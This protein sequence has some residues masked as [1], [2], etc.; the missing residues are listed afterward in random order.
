MEEERQFLRDM[1]IYENSNG[2]N[3]G[4]V[5]RITAFKRMYYSGQRISINNMKKNNDSKNECECPYCGVKFTTK[6]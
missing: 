6:D 5:N 1:K 4:A 2:L 3:Q